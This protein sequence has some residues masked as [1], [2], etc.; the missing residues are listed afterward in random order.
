MV[1]NGEIS[2]KVS[3]YLQD[4]K[5]EL[6]NFYHL[7]KTHN[8][9]VD[10]DNPSEWLQEQGYPVRG[11]ISCKG[12]PTEKLAGLVDHF[13]QP[14]M[15]QLPSFLKDTKDTLQ[16]IENMNEKIESGEF[17]LEG[18][19]LMTLDVDKM[20]NN[21]TE[22]LGLTGCR[23]YLESRSEQEVSTES[24]MK[25][26][27]LC[28]RNNFFKFNGKAYQQ[29]G[30]V[31]TGVKLAPPYACIGL[32]E[33]EK[34]AFE[35]NQHPLADFILLW[36]RFIDDVFGLFKGSKTQFEEYVDWLNSLMR[37]VVKFKSN[38][39]TNQ[40]EFLD[41]VISI[42]DGKL[43]TNLFVKPSNSQLYLDFNSNHPKHCK[44][45]II[46]GQALRILER[47]SDKNDVDLHLENL[48]GKVLDRNYPQKTIDQQF[49]RALGKERKDLIFGQR[50][51][52]NQNDKKVRLIFTQ[53]QGNPP[54]HQWVRDSKKFLTRNDRAKEM[55]GK[56]Q[57]AFK[58]PKNIKKLVTGASKRGGGCAQME[59]DAGCLKC[60]KCHACQVINEGRKFRSTNTNKVYTIRQKVNCNSS[61]I[62]YLGTC[63]KC[64]GQ[65]VGKSTQP[66]KRR[67]SGHKSEIKRQYGGLS[68]DAA[69][70]IYPCK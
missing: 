41:L 43:K 13:L 45:G 59:D 48:R 6:S 30:G 4:G 35:D 11:I 31:G 9:P 65:Y 20:Y 57:I 21:M 25:G 10:L 33:F 12:A 39:S 5:S 8:I 62:V 69:M 36:K 34:T 37:G 53:N 18:V 24:I 15:K 63:K 60:G 3:E 46:Y 38:F 44:T 29:I 54:I 49:K 55:G 7:L 40:V 66:F 23:K 58:Q 50:K 28:I 52:G 1:I 32:G 19:A 67:H 70:E 22:E 68:V 47:C 51:K 42:K 17:S 56:I 2:E 14:G 64:K 27:E 61:Y 16:I 26:L